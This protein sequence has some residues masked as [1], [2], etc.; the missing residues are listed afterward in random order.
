MESK[1][2]NSLHEFRFGTDMSGLVIGPDNLVII[3]EVEK[4]N[5]AGIDRRFM[6]VQCNHCPNEFEAQASNLQLGLTKSCGCLR[7]RPLPAE[8]RPHSDLNYLRMLHLGLTYQNERL[9]ACDEWVNLVQSDIGNRDH[10]DQRLVRLNEAKAF[11]AGN[12][13][14]SE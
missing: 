10:S 9:P 13:A 7:G 4:R 1:K 2:V 12:L 8:Q 6:R 14:W 11:D 5:I 3:E